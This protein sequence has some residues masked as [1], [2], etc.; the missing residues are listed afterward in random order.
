M[1]VLALAFGTRP[2]V[3]GGDWAL[4]RAIDLFGF[5][6]AMLGELLRVTVIG[7]AYIIR[8]GRDR[9]IFAENLVQTGIF[10]H[11]RNPLYL[12]NMLIYLG[13]AIVH[14]SPWFFV[15]GLPFFAFAYAS[16]VAA[17]EDFLRQKFGAEY[18]DYC[19]RVNRFVPSLRGIRATLAPMPFNWKKVVRAEYGTPFA[20]MSGMLAMFLLERAMTPGGELTRRTV[21]AV[22]VT[23]ILLA[24]AYVTARTLK[25]RGALNTP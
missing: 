1:V 17:E 21:N 11:S 13:L 5:G 14:G 19:R 3:I 16:L 20:W 15:V 6:V 22:A 23:W 24:I 12:G 2:L 25:L 9:K 7:F 8:G 18:A 4:D 10:A